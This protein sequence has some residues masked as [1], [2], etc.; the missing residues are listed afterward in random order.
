MTEASSISYS[1]GQALSCTCYQS[2]SPLSFRH[3]EW[4]Q[5]TLAKNKEICL[6]QCIVISVLSLSFILKV[7]IG[8]FFWGGF[9]L[10]VFGTMVQSPEGGE[11]KLS[12]FSGFSVWS[13]AQ[14]FFNTVSH[15]V[16]PMWGA[17]NKLQTNAWKRIE[18]AWAG[19]CPITPLCW[20]RTSDFDAKEWLLMP[21]N[22]CSFL[23]FGWD[24]EQRQ[25]HLS[26]SLSISSAKQ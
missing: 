4:C 25:K 9:F 1:V 21:K 11:E 5:F 14:K 13:Q 6:A 17:T 15:L 3:R 8:T 26:V 18:N 10:C 23:F 7:F 12:Y 16:S 19:T 24:T 22:N 2:F 20:N